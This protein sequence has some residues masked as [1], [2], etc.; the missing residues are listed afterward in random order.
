MNITKFLEPIANVTTRRH[1]LGEWS[2]TATYVTVTKNVQCPGR[3]EVN[4][5]SH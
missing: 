1:T 5:H 3:T 4:S 2:M